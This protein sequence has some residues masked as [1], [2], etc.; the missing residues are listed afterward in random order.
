MPQKPHGKLVQH[1][2]QEGMLS[3][4]QLPVPLRSS[5]RAEHAALESL[6]QCHCDI[7]RYV[8]LRNLREKDEQLFYS[9]L[10]NNAQEIL[11]FVYTP[12]V[13]EACQKYSRLPLVTRGLTITPADRGR[14]L[15]KLQTWPEKK[16]RVIVVTD[17]E[18]ILGLG[19][20]GYGGM[21]I[22][23]GKILLY[24]VIAGVDP[25]QCLPLCLD[26][27]TDNEE[28]LNDP[29]YK[30]LHQKRLRGEEYDSL[31]EE[32]MSAVRTWQPHT[33]LQFEDFGNT[34]AFRLLDKY[35][36]MQCC[37]ND[38]I[39]GTACITLAGVL[40]ALRVSA[41]RGG[42]K[43]CEWGTD[44]NGG[45]GNVVYAVYEGDISSLMKHKS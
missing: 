17:G 23:E 24:T 42:R 4:N 25:H 41:R 12:T 30:G 19:D 16:I 20:L 26:V 2:M 11:P 14:I 31:V 10:M 43:E 3:P 27:G 39:Q 13:G 38:D 40:S 21:G 44:G 35:R 33:L 15:E 34:N 32:L 7:D 8:Y 22:S 28:L 37:F 29:L 5:V 45:T 1:I 6:R 18:R 36:D 9:L